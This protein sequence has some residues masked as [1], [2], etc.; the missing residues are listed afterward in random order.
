MNGVYHRQSLKVASWEQ[1]EQIRRQME[2]G[3]PAAAPS[4]D[5]ALD[6]FLA[7]QKARAL[8]PATQRKHYV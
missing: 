7:E 2:E 4:I 8:A 5:S 1:A 6:A 3:R